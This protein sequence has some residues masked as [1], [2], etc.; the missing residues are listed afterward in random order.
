MRSD[1]QARHGL[2]AVVGMAGA[3][4]LLC[5]LVV[6]PL[7]ATGEGGGSGG[8]HGGQQR[9]LQH[10]GSFFVDDN[11]RADEPLATP[12]SAEIVDITR[13]G[14]TLVYTDAFTERLGFVDISD[15]K[16]PAAL[17]GLDLPGGPT[18]VAIHRRWALVA[19]VTSQ[20]PD[21]AGP[22]NEFDAPAGQ[23]LVIDLATRA[24]VRT[25]QL[26][27]QPDSVAISPDGEYA[28]IVIENERDEDEND[29]L[30]PQLPAGS[31][32]VVKLNGK[33]SHWSLRTVSLTGLADIAPSDP[34]PEYVDINGRNQAVLS[35][36]ENNHF[37]IVDL[38][39]AQVIA[40]FSAGTVDVANVDTTEEE[41]GPQGAG[42][43]ELNGSLVDRRREP[44]TVQWVDHNSFAAANEGDYVDENGV[45]GGSRSFTIW[46]S[47]GTIEFEAG[48]SFEHAVV[49]AGH[50]PEARSENKGSEPEG[51]EVGHS[52]G[53]TLLFVASER[54]NIV[55]VYDVSQGSPTLLQ[56]LPS[57]IGPEGM[58][59]TRGLLATTSEVDGAD[60]GFA[61]RPIITLF[62]VGRSA[63]TY[64]YLVSANDSAGLPIPWVAISGLSGD[65]VHADTVWAVS[66]SIL[67]QAWLYRIDVSHHPAVIRERIAI[68]G[69]DVTDQ[70]LG[71]YDLEGVAARLEGGFWFASEGRTNAGSSRPNLLV[72]TD[73][74]GAVLD[75]VPLPDS[76]I[77]V[78]TS[79]GLEGVAVTGTAAG[80]DEVVGTVIQ[81]EWGDD[82]A[83]L[84]KVGRYEVA[85]GEWTFAH[86]GLDP[87]PPLPAGAF[88]GLSEITLLPDGTLAIVERDNQL[89]QEAR[90]KRIYGIDTG[91][92]A[93]VPHG[94]P[95]ALLGKSLLRDVLGDL[96]AASISVPDKLEGVAVTAD[97]QVYL[98]TD[99][100]GVDENYGETLFLDIGSVEDAFGP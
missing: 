47:N 22:L 3:A 35:L 16:A 87:V 99:N 58:K 62:D 5:G 10:V 59:F 75:S 41:I 92:V 69:T 63:P 1:V 85:T 86:Y 100:D 9:S 29:G 38:K 55:G 68:G 54:A 21:G 33:P 70:T 72:R 31:L 83:G 96:D 57:G 43:I 19:I 73:A 94:Q 25:I 40:D 46:R 8:H 53:R 52:Q 60:E 37:V 11:L 36:Q 89:G 82:T 20:D 6:G 97:G 48:N 98:A 61:A 34:E 49:R 91:S 84:V 45:E 17:D 56:L 74:A 80:G 81:R 42:A 66:D 23:L 50:Y 64:P 32:Q 71:D 79:S 88:V 28:A 15:P 76:L 7:G 30:I 65:P 14:D 13:D 12:T 78:A 26:A 27:G 51:L 39:R 90:I 77:D 4:A 93:F 95:L 18:S 67:G 24:R 2:R 44:D